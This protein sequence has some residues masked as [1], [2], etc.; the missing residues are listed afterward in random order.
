[1]VLTNSLG[2]IVDGPAGGRVSINGISGGESLLFNARGRIVEGYFG[3]GGGF[4]ERGGCDFNLGENEVPVLRSSGTTAIHGEGFEP[5]GG[6]IGLLGLDGDGVGISIWNFSGRGDEDLLDAQLGV[7]CFYRADRGW[8]EVD[9][10]RGIR[11]A[12]WE[13]REKFFGFG[14]IFFLLF[15]KRWIGDVIVRLKRVVEVSHKTV[16]VVVGDG[17]VFVGVAL[18][19]AGG[20]AKPSGAGG[21]DAVGHGVKTELK[22]IDAPLLVE[23]GVT[24]EAGGDDLLGSC[25]GKHVAGKL[26]DRELIEWFVGVERSNDVVAVGPNRTV[27]ILFITIGVGITGE[28]EPS[29]GPSFAIP[30]G[31]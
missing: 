6:D 20:E 12:V 7:L 11:P 26:F 13:L 14:K 8:F 28:V 30:G 21:G 31:F 4:I 1:M 23:H 9:F 27:T 5:K 25:I 10:A 29:S 16:I 15:G 22:G 17:V 24:V 19:T 3:G 2:G 18:G